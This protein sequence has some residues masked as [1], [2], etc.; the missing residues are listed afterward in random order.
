MEVPIVDIIAWDYGLKKILLDKNY[1]KINP[2]KNIL[3]AKDKQY[4]QDISGTK[5]NR[6]L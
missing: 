5:E 4:Y 1:D 6:K 2:I 3:M